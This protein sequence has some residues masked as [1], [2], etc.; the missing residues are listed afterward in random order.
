LPLFSGSKVTVGSVGRKFGY[1]IFLL[2]V[3]FV[4][5]PHPQSTSIANQVY[6][7]RMFYK[8]VPEGISEK[9]REIAKK[10]PAV[11]FVK[12]TIVILH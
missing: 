3:D 8:K 4:A 9:E 11:L 6:S 7:D 5:S 10:V 1:F 12:H 2:R